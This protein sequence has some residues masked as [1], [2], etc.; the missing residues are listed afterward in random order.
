MSESSELM[1]A[2]KLF[3]S[4]QGSEQVTA[5]RKPEEEGQEALAKQE[6]T[7][8]GK[9]AKQ[10]TLSSDTDAK[11]KLHKVKVDGEEL[12]VEY[13][14]LV[15]GY[16]RET[17]YQKK[18]KELS[19]ER[20]EFTAKQAELDKRIEDAQLL[21]DD[22]L[23]KLNSKEMQEL[24][25]DDP[26]GYLKEVDRINAKVSKFKELKGKREAELAQKEQGRLQK[27]YQLLLEVF[28][29]WSDTAL[30]QKE[31]GEL[32]NVMSELGFSKEELASMTD[33]RMFVLAS[34]VK[35][36][37]DL[38]NVSLH[39]KEQKVKPKAAQPGAKHEES[40]I[41]KVDLSALRGAKSLRQAAKLLS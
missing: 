41:R 14:E 17:H 8:E 20:E 34:K 11:P 6:A 19:R 15:K 23:S 33:H 39:S 22:E 4:N 3:N 12:E 29:E 5:T 31:V 27:E 32:F 26:E 2:A 9:E 21:I 37:M 35:K 7:T 10:E 13:E 36:L 38:E 18:A 25:A 16:S 24:K 1:K 30:Q 40:D 28:P